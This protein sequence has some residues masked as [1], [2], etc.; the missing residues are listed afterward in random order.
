MCL[1]LSLNPPKNSST[2]PEKKTQSVWSK[3]NRQQSNPIS[4]P[5]LFLITSLSDGFTHSP[6]RCNF[7]W[8]ASPD[9]VPTNARARV[10]L[11]GFYHHLKLT[12]DHSQDLL[13]KI[14]SISKQFDYISTKIY[15]IF[16]KS[17]HVYFSVYWYILRLMQFHFSDWF[18][19]HLP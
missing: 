3:L 19:C 12:E 4:K 15:R 13:P 9:C 11:I 8:R 7:H 18:Q 2:T 1:H 14:P 6:W 17:V 16:W 5:S 10:Q